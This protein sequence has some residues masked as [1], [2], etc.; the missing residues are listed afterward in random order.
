MNLKT[1]IIAAALVAFTGSA[2]AAN[3]PVPTPPA[4]HAASTAG[5]K[6]KIVK[7]KKKCHKSKF[8]AKM[9]TKPYQGKPKAPKKN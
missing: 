3:T 7:G 1:V 2:M 6:C 8:K 4:K 5:E 9:A